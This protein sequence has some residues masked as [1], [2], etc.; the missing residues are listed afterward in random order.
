MRF[1]KNISFR[2]SLQRFIEGFVRR[3]VDSTQGFHSTADPYARAQN[4]STPIDRT[5][6]IPPLMNLNDTA[7]IS[8]TPIP[9]NRRSSYV[10]RLV[11]R[12]SKNTVTVKNIK[13]VNR[14]QLLDLLPVFMHLCGEALVNPAVEFKSIT[15]ELLDLVTEFMIQSVLEQYMVY[16]A[17]G[18]K[19]L[20]E[21]FSWREEHLEACSTHLQA[22]DAA[23]NR[24]SYPIDRDHKSSDLDSV[25]RDIIWACAS[26]AVSLLK[27][28]DECFSSSSNS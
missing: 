8:E 19:K 23:A 24:T 21:T 10:A 2:L 18:T 9:E 6:D 7:W 17:V 15:D 5:H 20:I 14:M 12:Y 26:Q 1:P 25:P 3:Y 4:H 13:Q 27:E 22:N 28:R 11:D 16:G